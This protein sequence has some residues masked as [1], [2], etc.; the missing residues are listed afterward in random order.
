[1]L[2]LLNPMAFQQRPRVRYSRS[3]SRT[4]SAIRDLSEAETANIAGEKEAIMMQRKRDHD[5]L[6]ALE[7]VLHVLRAVQTEGIFDR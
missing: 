7:E 3:S 2:G 1:M 5:A 6:R 4:T